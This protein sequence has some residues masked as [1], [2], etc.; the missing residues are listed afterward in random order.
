MDVLEQ[1]I[2]ENKIDKTMIFNMDE[3]ALTTVQVPPKVFAQK[4]NKQV[5]AI[6]SAERGIHTTVVVLGERMF[7]HP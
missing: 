3:S 6:T 5:G 2:D 4:G 7:H 1:V